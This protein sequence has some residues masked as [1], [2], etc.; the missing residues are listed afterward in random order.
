[1]IDLNLPENTVIE[2]EKDVLPEGRILESGLYKGT[3]DMVYLDTNA[4][5]TKL[6]VIHMKRGSRIYKFTNYISNRQGGYTYVDKKT[7][8]NKPLPGYSLMDSFFKLMTGQG[9]ADQ[10]V[11]EKKVKVW[12]YATSKEQP[13]D[14]LVFEHLLN[15]EMSAGILNVSSEKT[16]KESEWKQGTGEF[17]ESNE[18]DKFFDPSTGQTISEKEANKDASFLLKWKER[19]DGKTRI[20]KAPIPGTPNNS[21]ATTGMPESTNA[22]LDDPFA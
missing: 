8:Q 21:G 18:F 20:K 1:M 3:V 6:I 10:T 5:G 7:G 13:K 14:V 16:T 11:V 22:P 19:N 12:D 2:K 4:K 15:K 17:R 9:I